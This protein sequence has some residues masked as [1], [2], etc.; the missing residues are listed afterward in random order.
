M[1]LQVNEIGFWQAAVLAAM[2]APNVSVTNAVSRA[3]YAVKQ[4]RQRMPSTAEMIK[5][6]FQ[7]LPPTMDPDEPGGETH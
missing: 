2:K 5:E 4:L 3:D 7:G 1:K 6:D